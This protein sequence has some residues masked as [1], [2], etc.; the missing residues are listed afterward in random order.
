MSVVQP[1][2]LSGK[3][4]WPLVEGGKGVA[5]TNGRAAG[6]WA[7]AGGV[8]T[9]SGVNADAVDEN[10]E[11]IPLVF[12]GRDRLRAPRGA[13]RLLDPGRHQ[14]GAHRPRR[15]AGARAGST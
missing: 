13:D 4:V 12:T 3:E 11:Y 7:A 1:M 9:F 8:G 6:A 15:P 14:P 2:V 10:G 5:V